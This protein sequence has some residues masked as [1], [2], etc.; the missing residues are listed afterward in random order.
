MTFFLIL[1]VALLFASLITARFI[2][3]HLQARSTAALIGLSLAF[4][5]LVFQVGRLTLE[6]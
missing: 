5:L 4:F 1:T 6:A 3:R 2:I